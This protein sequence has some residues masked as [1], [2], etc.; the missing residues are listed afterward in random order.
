M[1]V[2]QICHKMPYPLN[3]GGSFSIFS[4]AT[5]LL[6]Q[7]VELKILAINTPRNSV[8]PGSIPLA[9]REKTRLECS[10]VDTRIKPVKLLLN[11]FSERSY[12]VERF[13]S[14]NFIYDLIRVLSRETF[15]IIQL[16][17]TYMCLYIKTIRGYSKAKIILRPQN[18]ENKVWESILENRVGFF[19]RIYLRLQ[20]ERLLNFEKN[21]AGRVDGIMAISPGDEGFFKEFAP[22]LP[23]IHVPIGIDFQALTPYDHLKQYEKFPV[24][25][26]LGSMDW[27]PNRQGIRWFIHDVI[28]F[29]KAICPGFV[30]RIAG[31]KM[32]AQFYRLQCES[33]IVDGEVKNSLPYHEDKSVLIVPLLS[34]GGI[35]VKIIE[36]MALGKTIISTT[37]GAA[38]IPY[39]N[40]VNILIADTP[41]EFAGQIKKCMDSPGFCRT[42]GENARLLAM[43]YYDSN[44]TSAQMIRFYNSLS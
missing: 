26:H 42:I 24:F 20:Q 36:A 2:L 44:I 1:K 12:F 15:D 14:G 30:F 4:T 7:D 32:P 17:H 16:E 35:R 29:V 22:H 6:S 33:L 11:L 31:K 18:A 41:E 13:L 19:S 3:D 40:Q 21:M 39:K 43:E 8:D 5:G 23:V 25:Y 27:S 34:G 10:V 28:P 38:G 9:F 37:K